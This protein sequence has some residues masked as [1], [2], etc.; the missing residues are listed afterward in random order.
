MIQTILA[1]YDFNHI[2]H[3]LSLVLWDELDIPSDDRA[4]ALGC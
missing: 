2:A 1:I 3:A 4:L